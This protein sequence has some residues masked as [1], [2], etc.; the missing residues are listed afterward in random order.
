MFEWNADNGDVVCRGC[1]AVA[2]DHALHEGEA[3]RNFD[4][5]EE[6]RSHA[7]HNVSPHLSDSYNLGTVVMATSEA[8]EASVKLIK[9]TLAEIETIAHLN[10][11]A[12]GGVRATRIFYKDA[13]KRKAFTLIREVVGDLF[14]GEYAVEN[15][16]A[17]FAAVRDVKDKVPARAC[18]RQNMHRY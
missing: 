11:D 2:M 5:D 14:L 3:H 4:D 10:G 15:A 9:Q 17:K 18:A 8:A 1:G 13:Q 7:G 12:A 16:C 6:D